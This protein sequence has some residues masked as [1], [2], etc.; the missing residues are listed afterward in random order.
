[1]GRISH[2]RATGMCARGE[3]EANG[4]EEARE[5]NDRDRARWSSA[6]P[7]DLLTG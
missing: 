5:A 4:P 1:M 6:D 3:V 7:R 2:G